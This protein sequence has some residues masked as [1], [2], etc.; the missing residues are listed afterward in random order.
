[1]KPQTPRC[2]AF[3]TETL[4][5]VR[6][7]S[8]GAIVLEQELRNILIASVARSGKPSPL[9]SATAR[10][11]C[12]AARGNS[13]EP[14]THLLHCSEEQKWPPKYIRCGNVQQAV[15]IEIACRQAIRPLA[16]AKESWSGEHA[17]AVSRKQRQ[18]I[19]H[20]IR[21]HQIYFAIT[22]EVTYGRTDPV[23][24]SYSP[25]MR[26]SAETTNSIINKTENSPPEFEPT[27][28]SGRLSAFRSPAVSAWEVPIDVAK[29]VWPLKPPVPLPN[30]IVTIE[31]VRFA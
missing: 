12:G 3:S 30:M 31:S 2:R 27:T 5:I 1:M 19:S 18:R 14:R 15:A 28:R 23:R 17:S 22:G 13:S 24:H 10:N 9:K 26:W 7:G 8:D 20:I 6:V 4:L 11:S 25:I 16:H 29:S 21:N